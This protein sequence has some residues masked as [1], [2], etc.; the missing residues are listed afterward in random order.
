MGDWD[1]DQLDVLAEIRDTK[2]EQIRLYKIELRMK[3]E[4]MLM[5]GD[6]DRVKCGRLLT[7]IENDSM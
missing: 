2:N 1:G 6:I 5:N 7:E 4:Q 3:A